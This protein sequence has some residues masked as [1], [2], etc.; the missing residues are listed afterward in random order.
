MKPACETTA[1]DKPPGVLRAAPAWLMVAAASLVLFSWLAA[2]VVERQ[3]LAFDSAIRIAIHQQATPPLT[4]LMR[5]FSLLGSG[6]VL[7]PLVLVTLVVMLGTGVRRNAILLIIVLSGAALLEV[8]LKLAF[9]RARPQPFFDL[10]VPGSYAFPSGHAL[11]AL[12]FYT[13]LAWMV[14]ARLASRW[15]RVAVWMAAA[16][17]IGLIG[18]SRIYLGVHY[19]SDVLGGYAVGLVWMASVAKLRNWPHSGV[20]VPSNSSTENTAQG[21][22]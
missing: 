22:V 21:R 19:P 15:S 3:S 11:V 4:F 13:A 10:K 17:L 18:L 7:L 1:T 16:L 9:H 5:E 2:E 6:D 20:A 14:S 12:C 8:A